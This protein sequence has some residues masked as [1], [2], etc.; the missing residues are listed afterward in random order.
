M[1]L[2][3]G[4]TH[5]ALRERVAGYLGVDLAAYRPGKMTYDLR[6]LRLKGRLWRVPQTQRYV[7]TPYGYR[8]ALFF[9]KLNARVFRTTFAAMDPSEQIPRPLADAFAE[10]DRQIDA[11]LDDAKLEKAA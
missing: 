11:I 2:P 3:S 1:H 4:L 9:T 10:V 6:R 8:V 5:R 7:V